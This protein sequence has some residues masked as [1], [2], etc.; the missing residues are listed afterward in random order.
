M[1]QTSPHISVTPP[2]AA[3]VS[4][5][6]HYCW[7]LKRFHQMGRDVAAVRS[8]CFSWIFDQV[9]TRLAPSINDPLLPSATR[10]QTE[11]HK[12]SK[13]IHDHLLKLYTLSSNEEVSTHDGCMHEFV[14]MRWSPG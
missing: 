2:L 7:I 13:P 9:G 3:D 1:T 8:L 5:R 14:W 4:L 6:R 10:G 12:S 11:V